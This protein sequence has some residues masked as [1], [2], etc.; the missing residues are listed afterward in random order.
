MHTYK[1]RQTDRQTYV[2]IETEA[3][4]GSNETLPWAWEG[5]KGLRALVPR[6]FK[7]ESG[8]SC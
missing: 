2:E 5:E 1:Q 7:R 8:S 4:E 6:D 3:Q